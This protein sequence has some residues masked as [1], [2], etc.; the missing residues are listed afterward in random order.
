VEHTKTRHECSSNLKLSLFRSG[1]RL[2]QKHSSLG[3]EKIL[4]AAQCIEELLFLE[5][6]KRGSTQGYA[7][8]TNLDERL[9]PL[10]RR[11]M[12]HKAGKATTAKARSPQELRLQTLRR[13][14]GSDELY[15]RAMH[16]VQLIQRL[17][18]Q[19]AS[20]RCS[21]EESFPM[22]ETLAAPAYMFFFDVNL[23]QA[24]DDIALR[25]LP[26]IMPHQWEAWIREAES[27]MEKFQ[28]WRQEQG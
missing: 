12:Q 11:L 17:R 5:T 4:K 7:D 16:L 26:D 22:K 27:I 25:E 21:G 23:V 15:K 2:Q 10:L 8:V 3:K 14:L 18:L 1:T 13:S 9:A 6:K 20:I 19:H 28:K 24:V